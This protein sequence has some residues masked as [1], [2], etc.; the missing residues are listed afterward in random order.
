M[1]KRERNGR[2]LLLESA[3]VEQVD[4]WRRAQFVRAKIRPS[5]S[6]AVHALVRLG[7]EAEAKRANEALDGT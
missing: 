3:L 6:A 2:G 5:M 7:L 4:E 1:V